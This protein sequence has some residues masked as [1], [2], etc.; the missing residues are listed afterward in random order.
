MSQKQPA[1][2]VAFLVVFSIL[3]AATIIVMFIQI[4]TQGGFFF[5]R[6]MPFSNGN[7]AW[8]VLVLFSTFFIWSLIG[9]IRQKNKFKQDK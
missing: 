5:G 2:S 7:E 4:K 3:C 6:G 9:F 1:P 8:I